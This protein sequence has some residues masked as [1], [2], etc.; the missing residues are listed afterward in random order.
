VTLTHQ[1]R[2]ALAELD[3]AVAHSHV[4]SAINALTYL[5]RA[6]ALLDGGSPG[7]PEWEELRGRLRDHPDLMARA[8]A[9]LDSPFDNRP[10]DDG[11]LDSLYARSGY[12][13]L[14]DL[15]VWP[16]PPLSD[17]H[18]GEVGKQLARG[19]AD[20]PPAVPAGIPAAHTWWH[21]SGI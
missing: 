5:G 16:E 20:D 21:P 9:N 6:V 2:S 19:V 7:G 3:Y 8:A 13:M 1:L 15:H 11:L 4:D 18:L 17:F 10:E 12:Q 14:L